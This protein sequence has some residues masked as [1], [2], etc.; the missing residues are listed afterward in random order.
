[1]NLHTSTFTCIHYFNSNLPSFSTASTQILGLISGVYVATNNSVAVLTNIIPLF[2]LINK[3][4]NHKIF[5]E[6]LKL[7]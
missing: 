1:M 3:E 6:I 4:W 2:S 7:L 5:S